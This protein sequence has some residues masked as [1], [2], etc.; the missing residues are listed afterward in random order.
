MKKAFT[1]I[2]VL[3]VLV[4]LGIL[5]TIAVAHYGGYRENAYDRDAQA[6]LKL[7]AAGERI[8]KMESSDGAYIICTS[9]NLNDNLNLNIPDS[10]AWVY[11]VPAADASSFCAQATRSSGTVRYWKITQGDTDAV[12][13]SCS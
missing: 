7:I 11:T 12:S 4:I 10:G 1:L 6:N 9:A 3:I 13:G 8:A 5:S 2:E